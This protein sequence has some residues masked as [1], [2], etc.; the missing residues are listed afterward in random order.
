M[1]VREINVIGA[2]SL[3][4]FTVQILAKMNPNWQCPINVWD[5]DKVEE[6][7]VNNQIYS[8]KDTGNLKVA[9]LSEIISKLGGPDIRIINRAVD[10][11][12]DLRDVVIVAVDTMSARK[13]VMDI[14]RFNWGVDYLIEARM[15]GHVGRIFAIDPKNPESVARYSQYLHGDDDAANPACATNETIPSLW[16]V[17]SSIARLVLLYKQSIVLKYTFIEGT[18]NLTNQPIVNFNAYA[19]I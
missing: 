3:G 17:A 11:K 5:F 16:M 19:L 2:G 10:E 6:H 13:K 15:G 9:A 14:C 7:N 1:D 18:V 4:S 12:T 8:L